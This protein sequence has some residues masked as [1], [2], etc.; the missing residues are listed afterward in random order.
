MRQF[1]RDI[2]RAHRAIVAK[3]HQ[4]EQGLFEGARAPGSEGEQRRGVGIEHRD[5]GLAAYLK[6][7]DAVFEPERA[8]AA[9][10][11]EIEPFNRADRRAVQRSD[12]IGLVQR[13][14]QREARA[15]AD[16]GAEADMD[17]PFGVLGGTQAE[18]AAAEK[19]VGGGAM[20][21][22]GVPLMRAGELG[23]RESDAMAEHGTPVF[24]GSACAK[25]T[26]R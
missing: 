2:G 1:P 7:A 4:N 25:S 9:E 13:G 3:R 18:Q 10:R 15:G 19:E 20:G 6:R 17:R 11:G 22:R 21:D 16:I 14:E 26:S 12:L 5:V 24:Q 8:S 23:L